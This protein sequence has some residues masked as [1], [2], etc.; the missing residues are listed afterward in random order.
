VSISG[1]RPVETIS[2]SQSA[3]I[4]PPAARTLT[5]G[6]IND[7]YVGATPDA[8]QYG[9]YAAANQ[10]ILLGN[11]AATA[12]PSPIANTWSAAEW[13]LGAELAA[14]GGLSGFEPGPAVNTGVNGL[15]GAVTPPQS[16]GVTGVKTGT[17]SLA[18]PIGTRGYVTS[19]E[20]YFPTQADGR[21]SANGVIWLQS[22][23][24]RDATAF[25]V[26][27]AQI[28][29]QTNSIVVAP[30]IS[31]FEIPTQPGAFLGSAALQRAVAA[32][33]LGDRGALVISANAAGYQGVLP[34]KILFAGQ[35][36]GGGFAAE[37]AAYTVDNGAALNVLGAVMFDGVAVPD[38]F[39]P[40]V[41][42][43]DSVGMPLYQIA[44]PPQT[45]NNWGRT[46]EQLVALH[47]DKFVGV[48]FDD[49]STLDAMVTLATGWINDMYAGVNGPSDPRYGIY[50]SPNDGTYVANQPIVM[51]ETGVTTLPA[52][53][54][55]D[56]NQYAGR[57]YEQG[58]IKQPSSTGL[59]NT[60]ANYTP[61]L[62]GTITVETYGTYG[63]S[64]PARSTTGSAVPVNAANTRL[65]V[66]FSGEPTRDEPGNYWIL[67]Y[68]PD[69]S[70]AIVGGP[71]GTSGSILTRQQ[72]IPEAE[73]N[74]L[75]ARAYRL[76]VR[77]TIT[78]TAQYPTIPPV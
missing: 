12:L 64:G 66:S 48:Q 56:I 2:S 73:Y 16:N 76:G 53:P 11:A 22:G 4:V 62:D 31:S 1:D 6:W 40:S 61:Q 42:K 17:S 20:W 49:G 18:I 7:L 25:A 24:L 43:L 52:P 46:T 54:P 59:V 69:Y 35:R 34:E 30:A 39:A 15:S 10:P 13:R 19:A 41:A 47:P 26:L 75:V 44:S 57:W 45:A 67:D 23:E 29:G 5:A 9:F 37:A 71:N 36:L 78:P 32:M 68:A 14:I 72:V 77:G 51:G 27:A 65:T 21:V 74:A 28:A 38:Q 55:V 60:A 63:Q 70:W 3:D 33:M 50:G 8:P 58:S